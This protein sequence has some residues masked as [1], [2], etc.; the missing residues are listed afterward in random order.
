MQRAKGFTIIELMIAV[1]VVSIL[2]SIAI[3]SYNDY[4]VRAR[5]SEG[6]GN[7]ADLRVKMEQYYSDN[8]RYSVDA[9]TK[10]C[11]IPGVPDGNTPTVSD[12]RYFGY[13][14]LVDN[15][16]GV[17]AQSY[18]LTAVGLGAQGLDGLSFTVNQ[19]NAKTTVVQ[20]GTDMAKKGYTDNATCWARKKGGEC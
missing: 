11:G 2:A 7:L 4:V 14:C 15:F 10:T 20:A 6:T 13:Q 9:G 18:T 17:G 5:L 1:V 16:N 8:R 3:P 19:A 12:G